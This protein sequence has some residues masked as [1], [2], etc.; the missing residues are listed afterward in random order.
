MGLKKY[1]LVVQCRVDPT[2]TF[3][4]NNVQQLHL[5]YGLE[6]HI[7]SSNIINKGCVKKVIP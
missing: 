5:L 4:Q 2:S 7:T 1:G 6:I 3:Y